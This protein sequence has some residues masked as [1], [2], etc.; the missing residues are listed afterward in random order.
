MATALS[1]GWV[2]LFP[3]PFLMT[4]SIPTPRAVGR[5]VGF[6]SDQRTPSVLPSWSRLGRGSIRLRSRVGFVWEQG[7]SCGVFRAPLVASRVGVV[8][9]LLVGFVFL[10]GAVSE[11]RAQPQLGYTDEAAPVLAKYCLACHGVANPKAGLSLASFGTEAAYSVHLAAGRK[12]LEAVESGAMPP[13]GAPQ[14]PEAEHE[15]LV[16]QLQSVVSK[17]GCV[18]GADPGKV[19]LRRLNRVEY[20]NTIRDLIGLDLRPADDFPS[21]DV[22]YG[23]DNNGDVLSLPPILLERYLAAAELISATAIV[24]DDQPRGPTRRYLPAE[25]G[26]PG[27]N[28]Q[29]LGD[30]GSWL[31]HTNA[32]VVARGALPQPGSYLVRA[33]AFG[34]P[35]G[36]EA[37]KLE[38]RVDG[39][40]AQS[41]DVRAT[42]DAPHLYEARI[43]VER[44]G[45]LTLAFT[46]D[47][48]FPDHPNPQRRDRNLAI[49]SVEV[50]GPLYHFPDHLPE[51]HTRI[52]FRQPGPRNHREVARDVLNRFAS[53]AYR[54][55]ATAA[56][57]DR[58]VGL[59]DQ[60]EQGGDRFERGIQLA[61]A[62]VLTSPHFLFRV[63]LE[64]RG[65]PTRV[66]TDLE[67]ASRLSYFL[68]SSMPD[69]E[70]LGLAARGQLRAGGNLD[71]Q[72]TRLLRDPK[73][74]A[75][76]EN[77][78]GQWLQTRNLKLVNP[79]RGL[80]PTF[81]EP[82]RA[83]MAR[84]SEVF[85]ATVLVENRP[86]TDFLHAD[87]TFLND[88]LAQ[89]YGIPGVVGAQFRRVALTDPRRGGI[90]TMA[91]TLTVTSNP[92]RTSPVKRGKWILEEILGTPPPPPPP[93][94]SDLPDAAPGLASGSVRDRL[95]RHRSNADCASCHA[96]MDPLG[97]GLE[98]FDAVGALRERDENQPI[99]PSGVLPNGARFVGPV[100]LKAVL[101]TKQVDFA[102]CFTAK[103]M[104]YALGR[105]LEAADRCV[106]EK[107]ADQ[108]MLDGGQIG[109][110]VAGI[111]H[112]DAF[113]K[114]SS[115]GGTRP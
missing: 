11:A 67:L 12:I 55:P 62:A 96:R 97:F 34:Q 80:F 68:W 61:V 111:V 14:I 113:Q 58:L 106:V 89:H 33:R 25:F 54:R 17:A 109:R 100:E 5:P 1:W 92:T 22:G 42:A 104:T 45:K 72:V 27:V 35:A 86:I 71:A 99:D 48:W 20:N 101:L 107:I 29:P 115:P 90:V 30:T 65:G 75:L 44:R 85:F 31:I 36:K 38:V 40:P 70:L 66:L 13:V 59:V 51:S 95:E 98:N 21:D 94:V 77:F 37:P 114:T 26:Q 16:A 41:F 105:G 103:L 46:N 60:V 19:T 84:E 88:R 79:D 6:V 52:I 15:K 74:W 91:S 93:G 63:E 87:Y 82:L 24:A 28:G 49:E 7:S 3:R 50:V 32:E 83:A 43:K 56:E 102:R 2:R 81:D 23:F 108:A 69:D 57:L 9:C 4:R 110:F 78:A 8:V 112:S 64:Q 53:R 73:A 18:V 76:V 39:K 47:A 10:H